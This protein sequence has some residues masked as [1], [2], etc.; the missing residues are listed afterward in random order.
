MSGIDGCGS[1][2]EYFDPIL[3]EQLQILCIDRQ[4]FFYFK[5]TPTTEIYTLSL[6]DALPI[7]WVGMIFAARLI[8]PITKLVTASERVRAGDR[9]STRLN[10]SHVEISYAVFCLK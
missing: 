7:L 8:V 2:V 5:H 10:S 4:F 3:F 1:H 9:K 6:H